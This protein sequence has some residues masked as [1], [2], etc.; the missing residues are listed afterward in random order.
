MAV[1]FVS[2]F[3]LN[4]LLRLESSCLARP[5]EL[6]MRLPFAGRLKCIGTGQHLKGRFGKSFTMEIA[7]G[8]LVSRLI[9]RFGDQYNFLMSAW[10]RSHL[11]TAFK[12]NTFAKAT[13][14]YPEP[15]TLVLMCR[16]VYVHV[17]NC[18]PMKR[19]TTCN[20]TS[21]ICFTTSPC[22][23]R[24]LRSLRRWKCPPSINVST[25]CFTSHIARLVRCVVV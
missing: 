2:N 16:N 5:S 21:T 10:L 20:K 3:V 14:S 6:L 19:R 12:C 8:W 24:P 15:H 18:P 17:Q 4:M 13:V 25:H 22:R 9:A 23:P 1:C 7:L 11:I